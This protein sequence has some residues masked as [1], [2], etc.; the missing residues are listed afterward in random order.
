MKKQATTNTLL[1]TLIIV[2]VLLAALFTKA[3]LTEQPQVTT[4]ATTVADD[5]R[6][7]KDKAKQAGQFV[8]YENP[9]KTKRYANL[10]E[11]AA[12]STAVIIATAGEN[13]CRLSPDGRSIT[14]DYPLSVQYLYKGKLHEGDS[15]S[16][17]LPGGKVVFA[18]GTTAEIRTPW[19]KKMQKGVTYL[20]FLTP[21]D[22]SGN[23][24]TTGG[25]QGL[26]EIPTDP[27]NRKVKTHTGLLKDAIWKYQDMDVKDFLRAVRRATKKG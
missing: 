1:M 5:A 2:A 20:L 24:I 23:F 15:L 21:G 3:G 14:I 25:A 10:D 27:H 6:P 9:N 19:F 11:L 18:D 12:Q 7:L 17:S 16:V 4:P 8:G 26:F 22:H 13:V